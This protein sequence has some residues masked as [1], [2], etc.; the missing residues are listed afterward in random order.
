MNDAA[1]FDAI[2]QCNLLE[3]F[4]E[5]LGAAIFVTDKLDQVTFASIRLLHFYPLRQT[6]IEPGSRARDLYGALYDAG[7]RFGQPAPGKTGRGRDE[8]IAERIAIAWKERVDTVEQVSSDRWIR[9]VSRRFSSGLGFIVMQDVSEQKKK[10]ILLKTEQ[11]R[12]RLTEEILDTLPV[13]VAVKDRNL[14]FAA[15]NQE[16]CAIVDMPAEQILGKSIWDVTDANLAKGMEEADWQLLASGESQDTEVAFADGE[17]TRTFRH[18]SRR[19]GRPGNHYVSMSLMRS[20]ADAATP[21]V[22][23]RPEPQPASP[24]VEAPVRED[25]SAEEAAPAAS[26]NVLYLVGSHY[27]GHALTLGLGAHDIDLCLIRDEDEFAAFVPAAQEAGVT[28]DF[29][30]IDGDFSPSAFNIAANAGL[31]F[32][33]LPAGS[34]DSTALSEILRSLDRRQLARAPRPSGMA[35][36]SSKT[37]PHAA[38]SPAIQQAPADNRLDVLAVEDNAI[39]RMALE[40]ILESLNVSFAIAGSGDEAIT[41]ANARNPRIV[42]ADFT[43]PDL[44]IEDLAGSLRRIAPALPVIGLMPSDT[45]LHRQRCAS[46]GLKD[47]LAKPLSPDALDLVLRKH[48]ALPPTIAPDNARPAA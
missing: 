1:S 7:C 8:W 31:D 11:D 39:N 47:G 32:R 44:S 6:A 16:F 27:G 14:H 48:L 22:A 5:A 43:L 20:G 29:V 25:V 37:A 17:D 35:A 24:A 42:L 34:E 15:V 36:P 9:I 33:M 21:Q 23:R 3:V 46:A 41:V 19:I 28:I 2:M 13:A 45:E 18:R 40:Q 4:C 38:V 26:R 30:L 12:V 10:E